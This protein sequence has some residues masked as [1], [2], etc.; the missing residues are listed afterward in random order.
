MSTSDPT[1][2]QANTSSSLTALPSSR[3]AVENIQPHPAEDTSLN[4]RGGGTNGAN[5]IVPD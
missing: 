4:K 2:L 3:L 5:T 1:N